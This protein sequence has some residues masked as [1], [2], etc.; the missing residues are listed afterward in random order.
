M[1][2]EIVEFIPETIVDE[3]VSLDEVAWDN[4][5]Q[6]SSGSVAWLNE[7]M[8]DVDWLSSQ[9]IQTD[10]KIALEV[11]DRTN[12]DLALE[13][14]ITVEANRISL[15][16]SERTSADNALQSSITVES[17]RKLWNTKNKKE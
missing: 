17:N 4:S 12:A 13:S 5:Q 11:S 6:L 10:A 8:W 3:W 16:V 7:T 2:E 15:E 1:S 14:S 9:I